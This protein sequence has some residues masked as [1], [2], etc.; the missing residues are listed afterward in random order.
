MKNF[1]AVSLS[2]FALPAVAITNIESQRIKP[3]PEG[4]SG[5]VEFQFDGKSGNSKEE[6]YAIS[7]RLNVKKAQDLWFLIASHEYDK[8]NGN[9][10]VDKSFAHGRWVHRYSPVWAGEAFA[11]YQDNE[12]TRLVS[13]YLGGAGARYT[14]LDEADKLNLALGAG[15][16]YVKEREDLSTYETNED[17]LRFNTYLS[18]KQQINDQVS[19]ISTAYYQPK[20][21]DFDDYNVLWNTSLITNLSESLKLKLAFNISHDSLPPENP[22]AEPPIDIDSTDAEYSASITYEF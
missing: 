13:R 9:K 12:F 15:A 4:L 11:Q 10:D 8:A 5:K 3:I 21:S 14:V 18:Y 19:I 17:Y 7:G 2:F 20:A 16:F 6:D 22:A 1:V